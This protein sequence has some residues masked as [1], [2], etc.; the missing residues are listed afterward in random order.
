MFKNLIKS[1]AFFS[2]FAVGYF[3]F[4]GADQYL[5]DKELFI[6]IF[7]A[8]TVFSVLFLDFSYFKND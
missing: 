7:F 6:T 4:F 2:F 3:T 1:T 8:L 5:V